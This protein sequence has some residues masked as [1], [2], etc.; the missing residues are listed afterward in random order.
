VE[1]VKEAGMTQM[2]ASVAEE[3]QVA[4]DSAERELVITRV[5]EAPRALVFKAWTQ[6]ERVMRWFG[7]KG[8]TTPLFEGDLRPGGAWRARMRSPQGQE[9]PQHGVVREIV[10]PER[11]AFTLVWDDQP[12]HEMLVTVTFAER[13]GKTGMAFR[14]GLFES[15]E[16]RDS[17]REGWTESFDR[18]D[19]Y[20]ADVR[21]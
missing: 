16:S 19:D 21:D 18:L 6:P 8:F 1:P 7:P 13:E 12:D 5:F 3:N 15:I 9:Y 4:T 14:Q 2:R 10:E 11:F 20:L 17:H